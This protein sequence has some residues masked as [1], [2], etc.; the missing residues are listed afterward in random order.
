[1]DG[2]SL[3]RRR[4]SGKESIRIWLCGRARS[5]ADLREARSGCELMRLTGE[6]CDCFCHGFDEQLRF[7]SDQGVPLSHVDYRMTLSD[8]GLW[9]GSTDSDG[10]TERIGSK[11]PLPS[12][13]ASCCPLAPAGHDA[14]AGSARTRA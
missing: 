4:R 9:Q 1:M 11:P 13:K 12:T 10:H 6:G 5:G 8:G 3:R 2:T 7:V 14:D